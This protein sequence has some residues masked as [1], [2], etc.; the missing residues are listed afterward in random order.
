[1][2]NYIFFNPLSG[3]GSCEAKIKAA[4][5]DKAGQKVYF[6]V[7]AQNNLKAVLADIASE[8]KIIICGGD[9]TL[10]RFV[11]SL[12]GME[13]K[14]DILY[15]ATGSGNDFLND[16]GLKPTN[17]P[18]LINDYIADLP[19]LTVGDKAYR[20]INGIGFGLDGYACAECN[21]I[22]REKNKKVSYAA[23][24]FKGIVSAYSPVNAKVTVDGEIYSYKNVWLASCMKG[25]YFGG[26]L[27]ITP[28]Q[29]RKSESGEVTVLLAHSLSRL[30]I[31]TLFPSIFKG[32]HIKYTKYITARTG[33]E[34][35]VEFDRPVALQ[36]DGETLSEVM[37]YS[38]SVPAAKEALLKG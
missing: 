36:I 30:H 20:F 5:S 19:V 38:V 4:M 15:F 27:R 32:T 24:A 22:R 12:Q 29:N 21:R 11:N 34:I 13:I 3:D 7:T 26:G 23:V 10:N 31:L 25:R 18:I 1:M 14:S 37:S 8:D 35:K 28:D 16:L 2:K 9:G 6:D 17:V 33:H